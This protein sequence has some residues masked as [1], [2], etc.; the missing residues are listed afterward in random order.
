MFDDVSDLRRG[1]HKAEIMSAET[2]GTSTI[3]LMYHMPS[4]SFGIGQP[5]LAESSL[6][7]SIAYDE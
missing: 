5:T 4:T 1:R 6:K 7:L 3:R 2:P